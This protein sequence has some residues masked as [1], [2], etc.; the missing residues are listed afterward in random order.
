MKKKII[1]GITVF[2][3]LVCAYFM[4]DY[5]TLRSACCLPGSIESKVLV[6]NYVKENISVLSPTKEV[7]G[8][9]FFVTKILFIDED[10]GEVEYEDGH[11]LLKSSFDYNI[12]K[13]GKVEVLDF[14][15]IK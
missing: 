12:D 5:F 4:F 11:I 2:L 1:I 8:G 9:K 14:N 15:I 6:E 7:L 10:S 3:V 13:D